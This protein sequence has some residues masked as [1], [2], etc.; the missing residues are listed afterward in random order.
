MTIGVGSGDATVALEVL[1]QGPGLDDNELGQ[2][3]E[4]F[5]RGRAGRARLGGSGLGLPIARELARRWHGEATLDNRPEGGARA[6]ITLPS[7]TTLNPPEAI[8]AGAQGYKA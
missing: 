5:R 2:V 6:A 8:L 7:L 4:R 1:D 3:F